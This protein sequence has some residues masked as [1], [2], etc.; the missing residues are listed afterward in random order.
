VPFWRDFDDKV[1]TP[2]EGRTGDTSPPRGMH[3][4]LAPIHNRGTHRPGEIPTWSLRTT[5][6]ANASQTPEDLQAF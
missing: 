6:A 4:M 1:M 2:A 3:E 5:A